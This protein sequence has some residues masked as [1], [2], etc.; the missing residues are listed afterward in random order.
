[1]NTGVF[2]VGY[3]YDVTVSKLNNGVSGGSHEI[4]MGFN[5]NCK[6]P[7]P[8]FRTISCPSF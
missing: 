5:L 8:K 3:S 4:S 7:I 6:K 1:V 2:K